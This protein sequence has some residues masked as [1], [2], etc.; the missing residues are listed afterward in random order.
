MTFFFTC[1]YA[2]FSISL[3]F[4][5]LLNCSIKDVMLDC[6]NL[7][8]G[9]VL[10]MASDGL[11]DNLWEDEILEILEPARLEV[12]KSILKIFLFSFLSKADIPF[13]G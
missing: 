8:S 7:K 1:H 3:H 10:L 13:A 5:I 2:L 4:T 11:F 6:I 12:S 9:D